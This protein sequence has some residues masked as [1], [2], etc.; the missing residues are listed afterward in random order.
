VKEWR[1]V[2][3]VNLTGA[4]SAPGRLP[5]DEKRKREAS[6]HQQWVPSPLMSPGQTPS[7]HCHKHAITALQIHGSGR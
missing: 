3:E 5:L 6:N 4:F 7:L 1:H 2:I